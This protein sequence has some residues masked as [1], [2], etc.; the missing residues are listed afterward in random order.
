[1]K[2][3]RPE[4]TNAVLVRNDLHP[5][6]ISLLAQALKETRNKRGL[7]QQAGEFPTQTDPEFPMAE[8]AV[9]FYKN[10][11][12]LLYKYLPHW[13]VPTFRD[14]SLRCWRV[15]QLLFRSSVLR[16][17]CS[18][19]SWNIVWALCIAVSGLSKRACKNALPPRRC[20]RSKPSWRMSIGRSIRSEF[21]SN[22]RT[23]FFR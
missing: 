23:C 7:F 21:R 18:D 20:Q 15:E 19:L 22:T 6:H 4:P 12:P 8:G 13:V 10:G 5:S 9:D 11:L 2:R 16:Q 3:P 14:Y 17:N 1:M